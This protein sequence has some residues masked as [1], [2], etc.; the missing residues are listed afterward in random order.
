ME[1]A[2]QTCLEMFEQRGYNIIEKDE[3]QI[4]ALKKNGKQVCA[5]MANTPKFN[6]ERIQEYISIMKQM[7]VWHAIIIYK[8]NATPVAK[9]VI[10]ESNQIL[11]ELFD[12]CEMQYNITKHYLVP[13]HEL[14]FE[15][16]TKSAKEFK[17]K[18]GDKFP[19]LL[20]NDPV[21]RFYG[22]N[23]G[24]IIKVTRKSGIVMYRITK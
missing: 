9:K 21:S 14:A 6:V 18:Y 19:F 16:G 15:K 23:T 2:Y 11:I 24:D 8:D 17:A 10:E 5:F 13:K 20:K 1:K 7:D 3:E 4:L 12:E 22:F